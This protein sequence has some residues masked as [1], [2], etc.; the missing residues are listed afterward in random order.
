MASVQQVS[1]G[2]APAA[3]TL[4]ARLASTFP[5]ARSRMANGYGL[6]KTSGLGAAGD[7]PF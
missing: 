4:A 6:T 5:Q 3:P 1:Y 2:G 7:A